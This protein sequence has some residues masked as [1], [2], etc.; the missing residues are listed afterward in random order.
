MDL[1]V[2]LEAAAEAA[3]HRAGVLRAMAGEVRGTIA[4]AEALLGEAG[5]GVSEPV[6]KRR[7][8]GRPARRRAE[9]GQADDPADA[10]ASSGEAPTGADAALE[11]QALRR[12][13]SNQWPPAVAA[14]Q[15]QLHEVQARL[16]GDPGE[17]GEGLRLQERRLLA[18]LDQLKVQVTNGDAPC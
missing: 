12:E 2:R 3:D 17:D 14:V 18:R 5:A 9:A 1:V 6:Q 16:A 7:R 10:P 13:A 11:Q 15:E 8:R 4:R